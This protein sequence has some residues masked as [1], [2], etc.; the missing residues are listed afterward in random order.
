[1]R[2]NTLAILLGLV[3]AA[4]GCSSTPPQPERKSEAQLHGKVTL[5]GVPLTMGELTLVRPD[6]KGPA[7]YMT[8]IEGD[9]AYRFAEA[10]LGKVRLA[11]GFAGDEPIVLDHAGKQIT[12]PKA[13]PKGKQDKKVTT[14]GLELPDLE[15]SVPAKYK[16]LETS[17][18]TFN[19][20]AGDNSFDI[21]LKK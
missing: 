8:P 2:S 6:S 3:M 15:K 12:P 7:V 1:M 21:K 14:T 18:L 16:N 4:G 11:L 17:G 20:V 13:P 9:G 19:V 5:D 10:P